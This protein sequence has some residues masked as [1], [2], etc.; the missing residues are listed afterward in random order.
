M[1][2]MR[3]FIERYERWL[4]LAL[5]ILILAVFTVT[6][7][8]VAALQGTG[9]NRG[10]PDDLA[11]SFRL[12]DRVE[13]PWKDYNRTAMRTAITA[14]ARAGRSVRTRETDVWTR[15]L[16]LEAARRQGI[17][18][19]NADLVEVLRAWLPLGLLDDRARYQDY[20]RTRLECSHVEF[21]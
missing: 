6:D 19:S 21:E 11:G 3:N 10:G 9:G 12:G 1:R 14:V 2:R 17:R 7:E 16:L 13:V 5:L 20:V 8:I 18:V 15:I 4:M